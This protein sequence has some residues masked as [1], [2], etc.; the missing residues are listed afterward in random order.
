MGIEKDLARQSRR[1]RGASKAKTIHES[2]SL[3]EPDASESASEIDN[4]ETSLSSSENS[5]AHMVSSLPPTQLVD[6]GDGQS[7]SPDKASLSLFSTTL[8]TLLKN[9]EEILSFAAT[10]GVV[11]NTIYRWLK[12]DSDPRPVHLQRILQLFP[13]HFQQLTS[14]IQQSFPDALEPSIS[15]IQAIQKDLYHLVIEMFSN[16]VETGTRWKIMQTIFDAAIAQ[17]DSERLGLAVM[18]A[19]LMLEHE[20]GIHSLYEVMTCGTPPWLPT[21]ENHVYL[22]STTLAGMAAM[23][24]H[25]QT[26]SILDDDERAQVDIDIYEQSAC[27]HPVTR[28]GQ[29]AGVL[30]VSSTQPTF[31]DDPIARQSAVEYAQLAGL[32]LRDAAF[33][34]FT[35]LNLLPFP[36]VRWQRA[37]INS[38]YIN[39]IIACARQ[40]RMSRPE[41]EA[42]VRQEM[43]LEFEQHVQNE[44]LQGSTEDEE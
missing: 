29:I 27:A 7:V 37:E 13:E 35:T 5:Q 1:Q 25:T 26:W 33:K 40:R 30:V 11:E 12:G 24:G 23:S 43:E 32:A 38:S 16:T 15:S 39:R 22:G 36:T 18:F 41:A 21:A 34:P 19:Q 4:D 44:G 10:L 3:Y 9:R 31:F 8:R 20:D 14:A 28:S 2:E 6:S 17:L 42:I